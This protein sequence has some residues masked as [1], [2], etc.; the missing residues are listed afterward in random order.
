MLQRHPR[1]IPIKVAVV[2]AACVEQ[3]T[4]VV[5]VACGSRRVVLDVDPTSVS[6]DSTSPVIVHL[7]ICGLIHIILAL[8]TQHSR[9][10]SRFVNMRAPAFPFVLFC[11]STVPAWA[12]DPMPSTIHWTHGRSQITMT[13]RTAARIVMIYNGASPSPR[14]A[15]M[16]RG[17]VLFEGI[18]NGDRITGVA[19]TFKDGCPPAPYHVEGH[20]RLVGPGDG[21]IE[22]AG[23]SPRR[24]KRCSVEGLTNSSPHATLRFDNP[25]LQD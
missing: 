17:T 14:G 18:R 19:R 3:A 24:G 22:L 16:P 5:E 1:A 25:D 4:S 21:E 23:P 12:L 20:I 9:S 10:P 13:E 7:W 6:H 8:S 2:E 15:T 11:M